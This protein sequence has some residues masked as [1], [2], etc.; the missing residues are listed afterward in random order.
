MKKFNKKEIED[1]ISNKTKSQADDPI[2]KSDGIL[3]LWISGLLLFPW[4]TSSYLFVKYEQGIF[5]LLFALTFLVSLLSGLQGFAKYSSPTGT[6]RRKYGKYFD[7]IET[8]F[9][10]ENF[11]IPLCETVLGN[12][13]EEF[14]KKIWETDFSYEMCLEALCQRVKFYLERELP[15]EIRKY[16]ESER[17]RKAAKYEEQRIREEKQKKEKDRIEKQFRKYMDQYSTELETEKN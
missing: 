9:L 7:K 12:R 4:I 3:S 17:K 16:E 15:E 6:V 8:K 14:R 2:P 10:F 11:E 5:F 13:I 1:I